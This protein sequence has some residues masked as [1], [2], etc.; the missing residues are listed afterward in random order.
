MIYFFSIYLN[1]GNAKRVIDRCKDYG[2]ILTNAGAAF[3]Y[4]ID[5]DDTHIRFAPTYA[6][7]AEID[8]A[9]EILC[10]EELW[11]I[12]MRKNRIK[13]KNICIT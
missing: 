2:V 3:P 4:G 8:I 5:N 1:P 11:W 13:T 7:L 10:E 6:S 12:I 9:T